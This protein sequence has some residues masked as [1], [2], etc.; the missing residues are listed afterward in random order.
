MLRKSFHETGTVNFGQD[1]PLRGHV[2]GIA[3]HRWECK[4]ASQQFRVR[5]GKVEVFFSFARRLLRRECCNGGRDD[6]ACSFPVSFK[7]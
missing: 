5:T 4:G 3:T 2:E 1:N 7:C 6:P